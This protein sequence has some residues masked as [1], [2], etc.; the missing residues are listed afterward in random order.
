[1]RLERLGLEFRMELAA[2]IPRVI[3]QFA[4]LH[5]HSVGSL[6]RELQAMLLQ[7]RL[8]LAVELVAV[9][10]PF[11]DFLLSVGFPRET[12]LGQHAG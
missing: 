9:P 3:F 11:A 12:L 5:V 8:I 6:A 1:M 2:Q 4:D 10:V 7:H